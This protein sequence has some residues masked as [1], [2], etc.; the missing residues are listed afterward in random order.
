VRLA[1]LRLA[2][3]S[4][5]LDQDCDDPMW[6]IVSSFAEKI[7]PANRIFFGGRF[8]GYFV[9]K[10]FVANMFRSEKS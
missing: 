10:W 4:Y 1:S 3:R 9:H 8:W 7:R 2:Y 6:M 5:F